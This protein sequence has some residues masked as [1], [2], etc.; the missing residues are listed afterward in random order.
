M[1]W[2]WQ[3]KGL[4]LGVSDAGK[5]ETLVLLPALSS[6]STRTEMRPLMERLAPRFRTISVDWPGFGNLP[7][8][9]V[10]W[11]PDA[12]SSFLRWFLAETSVG[13]ATIIAAGHAASYALHHTVSTPA[14]VRRLVLIAPTWR[15]PLPT[16]LKGYPAW[17]RRARAA[18]DSRAIGPALYRLNVNPPVVRMMGRAH[19][20]SDGDWLSGELLAEK[21][22]VTRAPGARHA[23]VRFVTGALDRVT[24]REDF[25]EMARRAAIPILVIYGGE[26]PPKSLS[27]MEALR[28][29]SNVTA[30][31]IDRGKLSLHEE[32]PDL[33]VPPI[34]AFLS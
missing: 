1:T 13:P 5:G 28:T 15:G 3:G 12:L 33:A 14:G 11:T 9:E 17:L 16:M 18:V 10:D 20:Y 22:R 6:I 31:R 32:F 2:S 4:T 7:R 23:S 34:D 8:P 19:V 26:T 29:L 30:Y 25:L 24:K 21:L 27:E